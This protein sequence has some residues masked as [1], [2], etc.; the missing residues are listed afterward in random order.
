MTVFVLFIAGNK[1][2]AR[3]PPVCALWHPWARSLQCYGSLTSQVAL[4]SG[5]I[6]GRFCER[7]VNALFYSLETQVNKQ[8]INSIIKLPLQKQNQNP[9]NLVI[10]I[11]KAYTACQ[12]ENFKCALAIVGKSPCVCSKTF[13]TCFSAWVFH[14]PGPVYKVAP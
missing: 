10:C 12:L 2:I 6:I 14:Q 4:N 1:K 3:R 11:W 7:H 8:Q 5:C 13:S 9:F